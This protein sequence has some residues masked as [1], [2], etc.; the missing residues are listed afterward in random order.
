MSNVDMVVDWWLQVVYTTNLAGVANERMLEGSRYCELALL[1]ALAIVPGL[2]LWWARTMVDLRYK[3]CQWAHTLEGS[4]CGGITLWWACAMVGSRYGGLALWW[5][6][7]VVGLCFDLCC[8][9]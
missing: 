5:A 7:V 8:R 2:V 4:R 9:V 3:W 6:R 1:W